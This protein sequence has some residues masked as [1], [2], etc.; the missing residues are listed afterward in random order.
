VAGEAA[1]ARRG[2]G[3]GAPLTDKGA[4]LG[5]GGS[6][7]ASDAKVRELDLAAVGEQHVGRLDV[8]VDLGLRVQILE[9]LE[10]LVHD[11]GDALLVDRADRVHHVLRAVARWTVGWRVLARY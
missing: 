11:G 3:E 6:E 2:K 7:L 5:H 8:P 4:A 1:G 9:A 10:H